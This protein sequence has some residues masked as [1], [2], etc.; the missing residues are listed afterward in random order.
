MQGHYVSGLQCN[1]KTWEQT[2]EI[3]PK[4]TE[5][6]SSTTIVDQPGKTVLQTSSRA[7]T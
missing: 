4:G 5:S 6:T 2:K 3:F 7:E 1:V